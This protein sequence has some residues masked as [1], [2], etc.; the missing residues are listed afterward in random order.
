[1]AFL[2]KFAALAPHVPMDPP[3]AFVCGHLGVG[4]T[5]GAQRALRDA[6]RNGCQGRY[7]R[8]SDLMRA[9]YDTYSAAPGAPIDERTEARFHF[10]AKVHL[11]VIDQ[12]GQNAMSDHARGVFFDVIDDR[13]SNKKP[14]ILISNYLPQEDALG[15]RMSDMGDDLTTMRATID[16]MRGGA[17]ANLFVIRGASWRGHEHEVRA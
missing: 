14:T 4:K 15:A 9:I 7:V 13:W 3:F 16:R 11:L 12:I 17:R 5:A 1:M 6:I 2:L 10:Y 8:L